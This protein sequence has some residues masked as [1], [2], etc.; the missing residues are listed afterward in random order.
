MPITSI[1]TRTRAYLYTKF[2]TGAKPTEADFADVFNSY[3]HK[4][5][6][7]IPASQVSGLDAVGGQ[8][9]ED[10]P[11]AGVGHIG[12]LSDG[13]VVAK[14]TT[15]TDFVKALV[16]RRVAYAYR[17]CAAS[18]S[19]NPGT[20]FGERGSAMASVTVAFNY[21]QN[22]AGPAGPPAITFDG[23]A[24]TLNPDNLTATAPNVIFRANPRVFAASAPY[25]AG[26]IKNDTLGTPT[27]GSIAAGTVN[28][29]PLAYTAVL[30]W[31]YGSAP[32][33]N[34]TGAMIY[35]GN[36]VVAPV[37]TEL[38]VP[39]F[40]TDGFL[41]FAVPKGSK[42]FAQWYRTELNK[43]AIGS[44]SDLFAGRVTRSVPSTGLAENW[45]EDYDLYVTNYLA[46]A[47]AS[48]KFF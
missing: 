37:G 21:Q 44:A 7:K 13:D 18:L 34:I 8:I 1:I 29:A 28:A 46:S 39:T 47:S 42:I 40:G 48:M 31:F 14:G 9:S 22:D 27:P 20:L 25:A 36:K 41:W 12:N 43:G 33:G 4:T 19:G 11:V 10:V 16:S 38:N 3:W 5:E 17:A 15:L 24:L 30:P 23:T 35:G 6:D 26:P 2:K 45:I 32:T